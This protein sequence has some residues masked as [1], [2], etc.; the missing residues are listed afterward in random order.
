MYLYFTE[1]WMILGKNSKD[2]FHL[3]QKTCTENQLCMRFKV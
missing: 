2:F 3:L 1:K